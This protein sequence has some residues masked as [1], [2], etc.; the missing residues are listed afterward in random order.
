MPK[1]ASFVDGIDEKVDTMIITLVDPGVDVGRVTRLI[2]M[3]LSGLDETAAVRFD[4]DPLIDYRSS[5]PMVHF[6]QGHLVGMGREDMIV[7]LSRDVT[8]K[9]YLRLHGIEPDFHWD[10]LVS[11]MLDIVEH[12]SIAS[13]YSFTAVGAPVPHTRPAD[14]I[15]RTTRET[16]HPVLDAQF[17]FPA[18]FASYFEFHAGKVGVDVTNI[19]TRVPIYLAPHH[20]PAGAAS[21]LSMVSSMAG[22]S[23]PL[24]DITRDAEEQAAEL[25]GMMESNEE[26]AMII[27]GF[28]EEYD[29]ADPSEGFV[30]APEREFLVPSAEEI[31]QAAEMFLQQASGATGAPA[32]SLTDAF[33]PQGLLSRIERYRASQRMTTANDFSSGLEDGAGPNGLDESFGSGEGAPPGPPDMPPPPPRP[34]RRGKHHR[35]D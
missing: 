3:S 30:R 26:L 27:A 2:D 5:R 12:F 13:V 14:M 28:E 24:G 33:D 32:P 6:K 17:W 20:Y 31:G 7:S 18:S 16:D 34:R 23:F 25:A 29:S 1:F 4:V 9:P 21:A 8:G 35:P 22:L 15:V 19:A 10:S 11:D